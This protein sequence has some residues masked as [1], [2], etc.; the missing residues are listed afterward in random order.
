VHS[1]AEARAAAAEGAVDY[2]FFGTVFR[3][4]T[5]STAHAVQGTAA[6][7]TVCQSVSI[8]VIAIGGITAENAAAVAAAGASGLAAI[9]LFAENQGAN[10]GRLGGLVRRLR[11]AF[12]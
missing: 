2:V 7:R 4:G 5:K 6:L 3:S 10:A 1:L 8:P 9:G 11:E 12:A